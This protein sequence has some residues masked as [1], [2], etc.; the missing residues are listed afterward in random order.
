MRWSWLVLLSG[1]AASMTVSRTVPPALRNDTVIAVAASGPY[2]MELVA[3]VR[4][5]LAPR[6]KVEACVLGCPA[7]GLYASLSLTPGPQD[8]RI[9]RTCQAE[10]YTGESWL[11]PKAKR[12][13][14]TVPVRDLEPCVA[15]ITKLLVEPSRETL[16]LRLDVTGP[17]AQ[18]AE[19]ISAGK[20]DEARAALEA[21]TTSL[22]DPTG[23]WYDLGVLHEA[24]GEL[25]DARR[26]YA[27]AS[28]RS[29]ASWMKAA[30]ELN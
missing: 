5:K 24:R 18:P 9:D 8:G 2:A 30:L 1:C 21:L 14:L 10:V 4:S 29:P 3:G 16:R 23:A 28:K 22:P 13:A 26:C 17:L 7:V 25:D 19:L 20:L 27:E 15:A 11:T 6:V 12:G